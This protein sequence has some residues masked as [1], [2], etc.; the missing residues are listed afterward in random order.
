MTRR[1]VFDTNSF[2]SALLFNDSVPG[3]ALLRALDAGLLLRSRALAE[4]LSNVLN[5]PPFDRYITRQERVEFLRALI[6]ESELITITE[7]IKACRDPQ[8]DKILELACNGKANCIVTGDDDPLVLNPFRGVP[9][10][11]PTQFL[12][13]DH[14][15]D[16]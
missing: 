10:V 11:R 8:D 14:V 3:R 5:R 6:R 12:A 1:Y 13:V 16:R 7:S 9:I 4:E 2:I 15:G